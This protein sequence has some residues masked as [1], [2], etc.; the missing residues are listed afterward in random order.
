MFGSRYS[1][2]LKTQP[3]G[4]KMSNMVYEKEEKE[5]EAMEQVLTR[6]VLANNEIVATGGIQLISG[7][8]LNVFD[9]MGL[10][11]VVAPTSLVDVSK[12]STCAVSMSGLPANTVGSSANLFFS[13]GGHSSMCGS[14][15]GFSSSKNTQRGVYAK[16][17][18]HK[19]ALTIRERRNKK[20]RSSRTAPSTLADGDTMCADIAMRLLQ[21]AIEPDIEAFHR[22]YAYEHTRKGRAEIAERQQREVY[23]A[24]EELDYFINM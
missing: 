12:M 14:G 6:D 13:I 10:E 1:T 21:K 8:G 9:T 17:D 15:S 5:G 11:G 18:A 24:L 19:A 7:G 16:L 22:K 3:L 4:N 2:P 23:E 20:G